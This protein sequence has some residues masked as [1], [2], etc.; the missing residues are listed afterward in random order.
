MNNLM[1]NFSGLALT[2]MEMKKVTGGC[3]AQ[4]SNGKATTCS[5]SDCQD[6]AAA[7]GGY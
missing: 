7:S 5:K 4:G 1:S 3:S 2:R 6:I